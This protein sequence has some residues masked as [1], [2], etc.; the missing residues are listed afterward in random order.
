[1]ARKGIAR[2]SAAALKRALGSND[3]AYRLLKKV[4]YFLISIVKVLGSV[5]PRNLAYFI[6]PEPAGFAGYVTRVDTRDIAGV[7][8]CREG[9]P[10]V[11]V[12][13]LVDGAVVNTTYA[14]QK[15]LGPSKFAGTTIGFHFPMKGIWKHVRKDQV[16]QVLANGKPLRFRA[17]FGP[18][19]PLT[20]KGVRK[21]SERGIVALTAEGNLINKFGRIQRPKD[22]SRDWAEKTF[23]NYADLNAVFEREFGIS[24]F[25]FYGA[26]LGYAREGG[27]LAHDLDLDLAYFSEK[28][29]PDDVRLEFYAITKRL[30]SV[31]VQAVP[32]TYKLQFKGSGLSVTPCWISDSGFSSTFGYVGDDYRVT[33]E[34]ILPLR[35]A[36]HDGH[37]LNLPN[38]PQAVAAYL[39]GHGW[40]YPDPGWKWLPEYK[41]RPQILAARLTD[42]DVRELQAFSEQA[43]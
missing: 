1:M 10:P 9:E 7:A 40:K 18:G 17:G 30:M 43:T 6:F 25:V 23:G 22:E 11:A 29:N 35:K 36:E 3:A 5:S 32:F 34:D 37:A 28:T 26:M 2:T 19:K 24:L 16:L 38:N 42:R 15:V 12:Q 4:A 27:I 20:N 39:Y 31:G 14:T 13:L 8:F 21:L 41:N 33:R